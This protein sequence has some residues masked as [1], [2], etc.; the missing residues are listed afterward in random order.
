MIKNIPSRKIHLFFTLC[1]ILFGWAAYSF[2]E[3][4]ARFQNPVSDLPLYLFLPIHFAATLVVYYLSLRV[5]IADKTNDFSRVGECAVIFTF[6]PVISLIFPALSFAGLYP[7]SMA[8]VHL[9]IIFYTAV[10]F[11]AI[12]LAQYLSIKMLRSA[13]KKPARS[14]TSLLAVI[15]LLGVSYLSL[16]IIGI[17]P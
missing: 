4:S 16:V 7:A 10:S 15:V 8:R 3:Q 9:A 17:L 14:L 13:K 12:A 6:A 5:D 2:F 11:A 1:S